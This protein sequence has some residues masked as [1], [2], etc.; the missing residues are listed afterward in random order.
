M[1]KYYKRQESAV[2]RKPGQ[3][4][5]ETTRFLH[6]IPLYHRLTDGYNDSMK[7]GGIIQSVSD[8]HKVQW[9]TVVN[10]PLQTWEWGQ[11]RQGMG[12]DVVRLGVFQKGKLTDGWQITF[13]RI[14]HTPWT[15][16]YF[17]KGPTPDKRM[18][19]ALMT[20][21]KQKR[22]IFIQLEPNIPVLQAENH[23][24]P[25][26]LIP[27][28]R[29]LFT[30]YTFILDLT[31]PE[32]ALLG[33]MH[34]KTR[35]NIRLAQKHGVVVAEDNSHEAFEQ[36]L[37]LAEETTNRQKFYAHNRRYHTEMWQTLRTQDI[38]HLFTATYQGTTLAAWILFVWGDTVYYPYG[39]SS[40]NHREVMAPNLMVWEIVR[41]AKAKHIKY[42]DLWGAI[43][44]DPKP[45]DPWY[46]FHR[47]KEGFGP[48]LVEYAGSFDL[49]IHPFLYGMYTAA[50]R[51]RWAMLRRLKR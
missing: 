41:W 16:G 28:H 44:P 5:F 29:P 48:N 6:R 27:A 10:H 31:K 50:D 15:V 8:S 36:Y 21:A 47:F 11:F 39:A 32:E 35:Y 17:P 38:A 23:T 13:H 2:Y 14:P 40:R 51:I 26:G 30:K 4:L 25:A 42:L 24:L 7:A 20:L 12:V 33:S 43:G 22:A 18:L 46:G 49:I 1:R 3:R 9:N 37:T 45:N 34:S 19:D